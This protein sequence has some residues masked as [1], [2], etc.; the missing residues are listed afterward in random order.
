[1]QK[2][3]LN[4]THFRPFQVYCFNNIFRI[5]LKNDSNKHDV[6]PKINK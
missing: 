3:D 4:H 6:R 1:M 2:V 5:K